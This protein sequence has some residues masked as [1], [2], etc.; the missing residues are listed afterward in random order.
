[1]LN[2]LGWIKAKILN[3]YFLAKHEKCCFLF[4]LAQKVSCCFQPNSLFLCVLKMTYI[5]K[6]IF[7]LKIKIFHFLKI[8]GI[9]Q[10][11][12]N[13]A[14]KSENVEKKHFSILTFFQPKAVTKFNPNY[15]GPN[16]TPFFLVD[17]LFVKKCH[18]ALVVSQGL[19]V[20]LHPHI[21]LSPAWQ[22]PCLPKYKTRSSPHN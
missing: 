1:M 7:K 18:Q 17:L 12:Q 20:Y 13:E 21:C 10:H 16:E 15:F 9:F 6:I 5:L 22:L 8:R 14:P 2:Y 3:C 19:V 4:E 11:L